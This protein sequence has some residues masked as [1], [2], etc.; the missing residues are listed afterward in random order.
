[1]GL[2]FTKTSLDP[3]D[4]GAYDQFAQ[5]QALAK[6]L[7]QQAMGSW[8]PQGGGAM[9]G[10]APLA[11]AIQGYLAGKMNSEA[12]AEQQKLLA[13]QQAEMQARTAA[14]MGAM[15]KAR[16][17]TPS[18]QFDFGP[19]NLDEVVGK[20]VL[21]PT[22][23][24]DSREYKDALIRAMTNPQLAKVAEEELKNYNSR[25][26]SPDKLAPRASLQ[27]I[28]QNPGDFTK[29]G[30]KDNPIVVDGQ[31]FNAREGNPLQHMGGQ[32]YAEPFRG[33]D[34]ELYQNKMFG[35]KI[36]ALNKAPK[37]N[38]GGTTIAGQKAGSEAFFKHAAEQVHGLGQQA[39]AAQQSLESL[40]N[41]QRM[42][43]EGIFSN[44]TT[45]PA[46]WL[47]NFGQAL[48]VNVDASKLGNTT[49]FNAEI[50]KLWTQAVSQAGGARGLTKEETAEIK[51][52]LP[53]AAS[54][55]EARAII[56]RNMAAASQRQIAQ[57]NQAN[58]AFARAV[59][60]DDPTVWSS[61]MKGVYLAPNVNVPEPAAT[62]PKAAPIGGGQTWNPQTKR[63]E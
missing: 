9:P 35:G 29:W 7:G 56:T 6:T 46:E 22:G 36:E 15:L 27:S 51:K 17:L 8:V 25:Q 37:V 11:Q 30:A 54:S 49:A 24:P 34:G 60:A 1:M 32:Q 41:L 28:Q 19:E 5:R 31:V 43:Q 44:V 57:Y 61:A 38:V 18:Q 3:E 16:Q 10:W 12:S 13:E 20:T 55:P 47:T 21:P 62:A 26:V 14:D 48:G 33:P 23:G 39:Y 58:E 50:N 42:E 45:G 2:T 4:R 53:L 52:M 63:F 40:S 59:Q